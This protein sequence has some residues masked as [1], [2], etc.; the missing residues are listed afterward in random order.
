MAVEFEMVDVDSHFVGRTE[1]KARLDAMSAALA[2]MHEPLAGIIRAMERHTVAQFESR[3][4][5]SGDLWEALEPSTIR[6][7]MGHPDPEWPLVASG[8]LMESATSP[9]GPYSEG[10]TLNSEA[11]IG[12]DWQRDGWQIAALHQEGVPWREVTQH[13]HHKDGSAY[14]VSYMWHLPSRPIYTITDEL[15]DDGADRI[16]AH[17]YNPL[18]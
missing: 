8:A 15:V 14:Q 4:G 6:E 16:I 18:A 3:G 17:I 13:R 5:A 10:A 7:K 1:A 12:V 9:I 11:W 2:N